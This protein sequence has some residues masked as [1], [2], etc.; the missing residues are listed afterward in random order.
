M[1]HDPGQTGP[2]GPA[3]AALPA[4]AA[5]PMP[6]P[7]TTSIPM[8]T[9]TTLPARPPRPRLLVTRPQPQADEWVDRLQ[10]LGLD[11]VALPLLAID[12]PGD[13][14][15][16]RAAWQ[17]LAGPQPP[18]LLMFVSPSAVLRF[19]ALRPAGQAWP[20]GVLAAAPGPGTGRALEQAGVPAAAVLTPPE[21]AGRFD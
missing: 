2:A 8:P 11:A 19:F 12:G 20:A 6:T 1:Q 5:A 14:G 9:S 16:V 15:A 4:P 18:A 17:R 7:T 3:P 13:E 21:A 10:A